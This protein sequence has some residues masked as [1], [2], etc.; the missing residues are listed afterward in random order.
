MDVTE[1]VLPG[2]GLRYEFTLT[3]GRRICVVA[4]RKESF[5]IS[6]FDGPDP[7][8]GRPVLKLDEGEAATLAE[9]LGA[10]RI[11]V[12]F[13]DLSKEVPGLSSEQITL[14]PDSPFVGRKLGDTKARTRTGSSI[15]A[16]VRDDNVHASPGPDEDL[17]ANDVLVVIGTV[18]GIQAL[19]DL[20]LPS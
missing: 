12:K 14:S 9:I 6:A 16:I 13:A 11:A 18:G 19:R 5:T 20:L 1:T 7:D 2:V 3:D 8:V 15:V 4:A 17:M 10:P